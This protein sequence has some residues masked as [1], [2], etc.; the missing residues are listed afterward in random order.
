MKAVLER[1]VKLRPGPEFSPVALSGRPMEERMLTSAYHD[2]EDL[3]LAAAGITLRRRTRDGDG[4]A[5]WQLKLPHAGDRLELAWEAPDER[6]PE[7][8]RRL[9]LARTRGR[10]LVRVVTLRTRRSGVVVRDGGIDV[11]EVVQ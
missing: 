1:E 6:V 7:A 2:T 10:P 5:A 3:R 4:G 8:V 11:A 9:L